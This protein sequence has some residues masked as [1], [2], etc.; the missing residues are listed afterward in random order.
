M[1][2]T[3]S[4][5][6]FLVGAALAGPAMAETAD[7]TNYA[8]HRDDLLRNVLVVAEP[9]EGVACE[10]RYEKKSEGGRADVLWHAQNDAA[11]CREQAEALTGRLAQ[12]G[13]TCLKG[14]Q[15]A[16]AEVPEG[17][18]LSVAVPVGGEGVTAATR[19]VHRTLIDPNDPA[20]SNS[21]SLSTDD[22]SGLLRPSLN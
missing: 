16:S 1:R 8:C 7:N 19:P 10:V 22:P 11:F 18:P 13:W 12:A 14:N 9:R 5:G 2:N 17:E 20:L 21:P 3:V 15:T 6:V 4:I